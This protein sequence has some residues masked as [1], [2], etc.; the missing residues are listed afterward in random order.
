MPDG[1]LPVQLDLSE[2]GAAQSKFD[3]REFSL[4]R[5]IEGQKL[6]ALIAQRASGVRGMAVAPKVGFECIERRPDAIDGVSELLSGTTWRRERTA[7]DAFRN[8]APHRPHPFFK[9]LSSRQ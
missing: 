8:L 6:T 3:T 7:L 9:R 2:T 1:Q 4:V 5:F